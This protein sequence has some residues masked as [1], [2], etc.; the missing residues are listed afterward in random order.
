M[1]GPLSYILWNF[2]LLLISCPLLSEIAAIEESKY[3]KYV[4]SLL[5]NR[6]L[7][8]AISHIVLQFVFFASYRI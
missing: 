6:E 7:R 5:A 8:Y 1:G 4:R 3:V 2:H